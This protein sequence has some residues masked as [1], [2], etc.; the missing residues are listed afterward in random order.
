M[1][2][3]LAIFLSILILILS[4][5]ILIVVHELGHFAMAKLFK[6][7]VY[8]FSVGMG[9]KLFRKKRKDGETYF[10]LRAIPFGG[11]VSMFDEGEDALEYVGHELPKERSMSGISKWKRIIIM[12]AGIV[13]N[14]ALGYVLFFIDNAAF[15]QRGY[16]LDV[17]EV[18]PNS[19]IDGKVGNLDIMNFLAYTEH[20]KTYLVNNEGKAYSNY[21][22]VDPDA[23]LIRDGVSMPLYVIFNNED[24][25]IL[26][27]DV[28]DRD[29]SKWFIY[30]NALTDLDKQVNYPDFSKTLAFEKDDVIEVRLQ[31]FEAKTHNPDEFDPSNAYKTTIDPETEKGVVSPYQTDVITLKMNQKGEGEDSYYA[32]E[33]LGYHTFVHAYRHSFGKAF[34]YAGKDWVSSTGT[35][36]KTI[37]QLFTFNKTAW[38]SVGGP[39][40]IFF[41]T[42]QIIRVADIGLLFQFWGMISVNLAIVNLLPIP[43]LDGFQTLIIII[44]AIIRREV[45]K[46][47]KNIL[48][49]VGISLLMLL[50]GVIVVLD[51][52][53][54]CGVMSSLLFLR[55]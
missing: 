55:I 25:D 2:S 32:P 40:A 19:P 28:N 44:E 45:P 26:Q 47:V 3:G 22:T 33:N 35:I 11:Y 21:Y 39:V 4:L 52:L 51:I 31:L 16:Y 5:G 8:E 53:K 27:K 48:S 13:L 38:Q 17:G 14:F 6:V 54:G 43:G 10:A 41:Q 46:K 23:V 36:F 42:E 7:Y 50:M 12:L 20:D 30:F 37:G 18:L 9:P 24:V 1:S 34:Y 49:I 15:E 29:Y